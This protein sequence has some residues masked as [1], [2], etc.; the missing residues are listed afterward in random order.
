MLCE[1]KLSPLWKSKI[2]IS[3]YLIILWLYY[4]VHHMCARINLGIPNQ[5]VKKANRYF[6]FTAL[7]CILLRRRNQSSNEAKVFLNHL[8][9]SFSSEICPLN[10][11]GRFSWNKTRQGTTSNSYLSAYSLEGEETKILFQWINWPPDVTLS[12]FVLLVFKTLFTPIKGG[13]TWVDRKNT[14]STE[15]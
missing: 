15:I 14:S 10:T 13:A 1:K 12:H 5:M 7:I 6:I 9:A 4:E 3:N 11:L 2:F 8:I